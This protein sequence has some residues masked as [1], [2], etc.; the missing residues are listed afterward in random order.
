MKDFERLIMKDLG[1]SYGDL[2]V[3]RD[4]NLTVDRGEF[5]TLLGPSGCGKSTALNCISGLLHINEGRIQIDDEILDDGRHVFVS[6]EK[7]G[8]GII[9]QNYALFPHMTV[10]N[11]IAFG[12]SVSHKHKDEI[13]KRVEEAIRMVHL[14][15]QE[16]KFPSQLS[17]GQQQRVAIARS[18]VI[19]PRLLLLDEPL[20]NLDTKLRIEMRYE[21]KQIHKRLKRA[22]VYVTHDQ[23]EALALSDK[24]VIMKIGKIQQIGTPKEVYLHPANR[25]VADFM[26]YKNIWEAKICEITESQGQRQI[27]LES[28]GFKFIS[29]STIAD[30]I[31]VDTAV[32]N[33]AKR[34]EGVLVAIRP[35]DITFGAAAVNTLEATVEV[36]EYLGTANQ[37]SA[38]F[39]D[40]T[41][42]QARVTPSHRISVNDRV[43]F[44][45]DPQKIV[46]IP[47]DEEEA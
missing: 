11:N 33:A 18:V 28:K 36:T 1:K 41:L 26:G 17:G 15:G 34:G 9:F 31:Q 32:F 8:F 13:K 21:L 14:E 30:N 47:E 37:I 25:F 4:F 7:R 20:S 16:Q 42:M 43:S 45:I 38:K 46:V 44:H 39:T 27:L 19:E 22:S 10:F 23:S 40:D 2:H 24:I 12:L 5:V 3:L 29:R 35:D 6:P